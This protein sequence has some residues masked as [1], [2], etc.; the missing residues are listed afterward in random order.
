M[1]QASP[2]CPAPRSIVRRAARL[3]PA[4]VALAMIL[5]AGLAS[6]IAY[7]AYRPNG[8]LIDP[9]AGIQTW[10]AVSDGMHNSNTD[11]TFWRGQF[12]LIHAR[13]RWHF[14]SDRCKLLL[15][16][17]PDA[18]TWE[19]VAEFG[20]PQQDI[21][22]PKL[23]VIH[24]RLFAYALRN[25]TFNPEPCMTA[26]T[27]SDDGNAWTPLQDV[28][29]K[30]WLF[31][32]PKTRDG[33]TWYV[34][35]YWNEH[36]KSILLSSTDGLHW[37]EVSIIH[38]GDRNDETAIEFLP[39]GRMIATA[40]LEFSE[41]YFGDARACT[42]IAVAQ[43]PYREWSSA[44]S[45]ETRLDGPCL[46]SYDGEVYALGRRNPDPQGFLN[47]YGSILG[48]KRTSLYKV[49]EYRL[50][51]L[52]DLPS[53]GDTSYIGAV[54]KDGELFASY[55]TSRIDRDFPWIMGMLSASDIRIARMPLSNLKLLAKNR[56]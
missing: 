48:R 44:K 17:S 34:P 10:A 41:D 11:L 42:L 45:Y 40:R 49:E 28:D 24:D 54:M 6:V 5:A 39:D 21:R 8:S 33:T 32:R 36:G 52:T 15:W 2:E 9:K 37:S 31:W 23:A 27:Y 19:R 12:Y 1:E 56:D 50:L 53:A 13:S 38:E 51:F 43:P 18:R 55:Y 20:I 46:F 7:W 14:G 3:L 35:A 30:G 26:V 22:D 16:R 47:H 4:C 29:P 25:I